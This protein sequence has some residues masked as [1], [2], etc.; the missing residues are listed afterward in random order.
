[1]SDMTGVTGPILLVGCGK[2]GSALLGGWLDQGIAADQVLVVEPALDADRSA[3]PDGV[4]VL[5][6]EMSLGGI[7]SR[8]D[9]GLLTLYE[10]YKSLE[11][12]KHYKC[13]KYPIWLIHSESH[14]SIAFAVDRD[15]ERKSR[16]KF[17]LYY[18]DGLAHWEETF[19]LTVDIS[20]AVVFEA[21]DFT[22]AVENCLRCKWPTAEIDWNGST[23]IM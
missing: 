5:D 14:F 22:S 3:V 8:A 20:S 6:G 2:M 12:G 19:R 16:D 17:D 23:V 18:Y 1:M 11:V 4:K 13:P 15:I 21:D 7:E 9:A 10:H